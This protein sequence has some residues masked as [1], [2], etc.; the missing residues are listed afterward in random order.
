[1]HPNN[2][3]IMIVWLLLCMTGALGPIA[4]GAHGVGLVVGLL[5]AYLRF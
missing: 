4:N 2:V 1:M 5:A 3:T